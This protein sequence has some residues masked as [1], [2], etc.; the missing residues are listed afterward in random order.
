MSEQPPG[1]EQQPQ[2]EPRDRA[3]LRMVNNGWANAS[4]G[5]EFA[6]TGFFARISNTEPELGEIVDAFR[7]EFA[8]AELTDHSQ[9][10][11]HFLLTDRFGNVTVTDYPDED[12]LVA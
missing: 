4:A 6:P 9:L 12:S 5:S 8:D 11:G 2:L 7:E 3:L 1:P 10:V